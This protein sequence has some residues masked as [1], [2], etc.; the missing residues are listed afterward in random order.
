MEAFKEPIRYFEDYS[1]VL[2]HYKKTVSAT[3]DPHF[4]ELHGEPVFRNQELC[5][6]SEDHSEQST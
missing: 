3:S 5:G 2:H 6:Q 1:D 4:L